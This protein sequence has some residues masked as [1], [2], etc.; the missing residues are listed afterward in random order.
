[1]ESAL[2]IVLCS[3]LSAQETIR[4]TQCSRRL[5]SSPNVARI[6]ELLLFFHVQAVADAEA[7]AEAEELESEEEGEAG[8]ER[9]QGV[10]RVG[11]ANH[12]H[13]PYNRIEQPGPAITT[14]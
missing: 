14:Y 9:R 8:A 7:E 12:H 2:A 10:L 6:L 5:Y 11:L 3:E 4:L 1:M 13:A